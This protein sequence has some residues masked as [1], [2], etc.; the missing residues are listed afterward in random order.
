MTVRANFA[1]PT[2]T[3]G[4]ICTSA[5]LS[6]DGTVLLVNAV[7]W[8]VPPASVVVFQG[9]TFKSAIPSNTQV[10]SWG[11]Y[12]EELAALQAGTM[13]EIAC[14]FDVSV[15]GLT[16]AQVQTICQQ[17]AATKW[18]AAQTALTNSASPTPVHFVG[19]STPGPAVSVW[20]GGP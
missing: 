12:P 17:Q 13:R 9:P 14:S 11:Y 6:A 16:A 19:A 20:T 15:T 1:S 5:N 10:P 4:I 7:F 8:L 3:G 2:I 18:T